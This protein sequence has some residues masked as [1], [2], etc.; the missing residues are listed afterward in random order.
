MIEFLIVQQIV[1]QS[2]GNNITMNAIIRIVT[3]ETKEA[4]IGKFVIATSHIKPEKK[5]ELLVYQ[6]NQVSTVV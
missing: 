4:A 1:E 2:V 3:A 5:L 6:L